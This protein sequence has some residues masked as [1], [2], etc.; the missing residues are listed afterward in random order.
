MAVYDGFFDAV[1]DESTFEYDR[2]YNSDDFTGYFGELIG[3]GVCVHEN[4]NSMLV[5]FDGKS[6]VVAPGYLFIRGY[7]LKNTEN[8]NIQIPTSGT[9]AIL[10][11]LNTG[12]RR[13]E[14][15]YTEKA[16]PEKY[17]DALVLAYVT[18]APD[19]SASVE[20]TR[21]RT[22]ICGVI[23]SAGS[24]SKKVE[25]AINYIDNEID[26]KLAEADALILEQSAMLDK[27]VEE[28][29]AMVEKMAPPPIGTVKFS[30]S[31][32]IE[33]GWLRCDGRF[34]SEADYP[35][36]V[37]ALG[38]KY[39]SGDKFVVLSDGEIGQGISNGAV[40]GGR[41]WVY[42]HTAKT[43]YG[44]ST[45]GDPIK[46]IAVKSSH[47]YFD[48]F[49]SPTPTQPIA[50]SIVPHKIGDGAKL[51]LAQ[52]LK[53]GS[54]EIGSEAPTTGFEEYFLLFSAE[55]TG[56]ESEISLDMPVTAV[57]THVQTVSY[58]NSKI[59]TVAEWDTDIVPYVFSELAEGKEHYF[60]LIR[61]FV[62]SKPSTG[63]HGFA[64]LEWSGETKT[65]PSLYERKV[66]LSAGGIRKFQRLA[67]SPNNKGEAVSVRAYGNDNGPAENTY[68]VYSHPNRIF[69]FDEAE[70]AIDE[71]DQRTAFLP[72][73]IAGTPAVVYDIQKTGFA[74][75]RLEEASYSYVKH[76]IAMPSSA[77]VFY[78]AGCYLDGKDIYL[79]FVGT[80]ILFSRK[81]VAGDV[82]YLDTSGV[83][84][85]ITQ[86][87]NMMHS[88]D[89]NTLYLLGQDTANR[90]K[91]AKMELNT[92][93]DYANDGAWLPMI[94]SDGVPAYI[95][96][97]EV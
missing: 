15:G 89:E 36:L 39:P 19:G 84:G 78:D 29:N 71:T 3:S 85:T 60:C 83:I 7:W 18:I 30:A 97:L 52:V 65:A 55:F 76:G 61:F 11:T 96:A 64:R 27:K 34:I 54:G 73:P 53:D 75:A 40:Y 35:E 38:K 23:N 87:G 51:F 22:D 28:V 66:E 69:V 17:E 24:L 59:Y 45:S 33:D 48:T 4:E 43:L 82:G 2:E 91:V 95:K 57:E 90:V 94:A 49:L 88:V 68:T 20:D 42:S 26:G 41:V 8:Y 44:V 77:R 56:E 14:L 79:I 74:V 16:E 63:S 86:Y 37:A 50:L 70:T 10:A 32:A 58:D 5:G 47:A 12:D 1:L 93:F 81:L 62:A 67:F 25:F 92:L 72:L 13:I 46:T 21:H 6:A 80:G 9:Y 31:S